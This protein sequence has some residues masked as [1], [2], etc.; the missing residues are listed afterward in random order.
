MRNELLQGNLKSMV[1]FAMDAGRRYSFESVLSRYVGVSGAWQARVL[2][3]CA[4]LVAG[5]AVITWLYFF[6]GFMP[7]EYRWERPCK[8]L[9]AGFFGANA[10][11]QPLL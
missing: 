5:E 2:L 8:S 7:D 3:G 6:V 11:T 9:S 1:T 10:Q 4:L